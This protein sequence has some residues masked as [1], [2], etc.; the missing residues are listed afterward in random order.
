MTTVETRSDRIHRRFEIAVIAILR[1]VL[2]IVIALAIIELCLIILDAIS[3]NFVR[4]EIDGAAG[5]QSI[6]D[7]QR[8]VQ[9]AF[10][11][12]L[13][14]ILGLELLETLRTYFVEHRTRLR[15]IFVVAMI[16]VGRHII[17]LDFDH[18]TGALLA[19]I[20]VLVLTL[21]ASYYLMTRFALVDPSAAGPQPSRDAGTP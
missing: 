2:A 9:R 7:L 6:P 10:A 8:A 3:V 4:R 1:I 21:S 12:V 14:V 11:A 16:A 15:V 5:I 17:Q 18:I 20:A 19:G 13:L